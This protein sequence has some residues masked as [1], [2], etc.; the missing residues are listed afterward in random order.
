MRGALPWL[1]GVALLIGLAFFFA[2][3]RPISMN[4][5]TLTL[6]S[7]RSAEVACERPHFKLEPRLEMGSGGSAG[8]LEEALLRL[9]RAPD[10]AMHPLRDPA[11]VSDLRGVLE[12]TRRQRLLLARIAA[13]FTPA[14]NAALKRVGLPA[15]DAP[16]DGA[17]RSAS[18]VCLDEALEGMAADAHD[19]LEQRTLG[20]VLSSRAS[21]TPRVDGASPQIVL[22]LVHLILQHHDVS[23]ASQR[24]SWL[25]LLAALQSETAVKRARLRDVLVRLSA[26][27]RA[28]IEGMV[29]AAGPGATSLGYQIAT[30]ERLLAL[31][32]AVA[33]PGPGLTVPRTVR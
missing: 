10:V 18:L 31:G 17:S 16:G 6:S 21:P 24:A 1:V 4:R 20:T 30:I 26:A 7:E 3:S 22:S 28:E 15:S 23:T 8:V 12:A 32:D 27:Q 33:S 19:L 11:V 25:E 29:R 5:V 14:Q 2:S 9:E 13:S